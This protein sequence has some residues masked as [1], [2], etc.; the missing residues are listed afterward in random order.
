M[1]K[2]HNAKGAGEDVVGCIRKGKGLGAGFAEFDVGEAFLASEFLRKRNHAWSE[3][4]GGHAAGGSHFAH[5]GKRGI[6]DTALEIDDAHPAATLTAL[7]NPFR[8]PP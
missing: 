8:A 5:D 3:I 4:G 2:K 1:G 7:D 6:A